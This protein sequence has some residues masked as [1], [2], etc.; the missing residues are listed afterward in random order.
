MPSRNCRGFSLSKVK[1]FMNLSTEAP[2]ETGVIA[3][4]E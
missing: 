1:E 3:S 4:K 2:S